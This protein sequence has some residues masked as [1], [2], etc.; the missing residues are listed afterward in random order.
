LDETMAGYLISIA[1]ESKERQFGLRQ[2]IDAP[3]L[4][5]KLR[6]ACSRFH[7]HMIDREFHRES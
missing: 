3:K 2:G 1:L 6:V 5:A 7:G 4:P